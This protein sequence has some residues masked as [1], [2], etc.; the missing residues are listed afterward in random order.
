MHSPS[1]FEFD[2][3][4]VSESIHCAAGLFRILGSDLAEIPLLTCRP[5]LQGLGLTRL[6]LQHL[7]AML[8][9]SAKPLPAHKSFYCMLKVDD[10]LCGCAACLL[11]TQFC[12]FPNSSRRSVEA[13][14]SQKMV[15]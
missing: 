13:R 6:L 9:R 1:S 14:S 12:I 15:T 5:D 8:I 3:I 7:E 2:L 4:V 11:R 10:K